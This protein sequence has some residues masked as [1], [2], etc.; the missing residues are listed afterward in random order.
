MK[1]NDENFGGWNPCSSPESVTKIPE[2]QKPRGMRV[3]KKVHQ[4]KPGK[5]HAMQILDNGGG[6]KQGGFDLIPSEKVV[7]CLDVVGVRAGVECKG[8]LGRR[9]RYI[10]CKRRIA[11]RAFNMLSCDQVSIRDFEL[12]DDREDIFFDS[13]DSLETSLNSKPSASNLVEKPELELRENISNEFLAKEIS[14]VHERCKRFLRETGFDTLFLSEMRCT[15]EPKVKINTSLHQTELEMMSDSLSIPEYSGEEDSVCMSAEDTEND[16]NAMLHE[17]GPNRTMAW[18][19]TETQIESHVDQRLLDQKRTV[20]GNTNLRKRWWARLS[21]KRSDSDLL[22]NDALLRNS[23]ASKALV[24][25]VGFHNS[26][27]ITEFRMIQ[28]IAAHKGLIRT[29]KFSPCGTYLATGG[30]D[31][32]VRVWKVRKLSTDDLRRKGFNFSSTLSPDDLQV[33]EVP[34]HEYFGH[35]SD[36]LD[37]S[38]SR[39]SCLLSASKDKTVRMWK[40]GCESCVKVFYHNDY[41]TCVQFN[42]LDDAHFISGSLDR[43]VRI[44]S[45][46]KNIV[47]NWVDTRSIITAISYQADGKGFVAGTLTGNCRFYVCSGTGN[48]LQLDKELYVWGKN[49][50]SGKQITGLQCT[51]DSKVVITSVDS[52]VCIFDGFKVVQKFRGSWKSKSHVAASVTADGR[53]IVSVGEKSNICIRD[54]YSD[55]GIPS[56]KAMKSVFSCEHFF[57]EGVTVA[58]PWV[59]VEGGEAC[60][61]KSQMA[62]SVPFEQNPEIFVKYRNQNLFSLGSCLRTTGAASISATWPEEKLPASSTQVKLPDLSDCHHQSGQEPALPVATSSLVFV[63]GSCSGMIRL[64]RYLRSP[65]KVC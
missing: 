46:D 8:G 37:L 60:L 13:F 5:L 29:M 9:G 31:C 17:V 53:Y 14:A 28:E 7:Y 15:E 1:L 64:F 52:K 61:H 4:V 19:E 47:V 6:S 48:N 33:E 49:K 62:S 65:A 21:T 45:V 54:H 12:D 38:W 43:K 55:M 63:T 34:L 10:D 59:T 22:T 16:V 18:L 39:S 36:I 50:S 11:G 32:A 40:V 42:P 23:L 20:K 30:E 57:P 41:V 24:K 35:T 27:E 2:R 44:W 3:M 51:G 26:R 25:K 56:K 58:V